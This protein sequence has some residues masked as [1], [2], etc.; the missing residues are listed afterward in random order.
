MQVDYIVIG[1]GSAG[2][3]V[4]ERLSQSG[5]YSVLLLETGGGLHNPWISVPAGFGATY[6]HPKYNYMYYSEK[7]VN[8]NNRQLYVPR[9]KGL[10]GSGSINA[11]IYVRGARR[12]FDDWAKAG[13]PSWAY[14]QVLPYFKQ[15]E[16]HPQGE[17]DYRGAHGPI[18]I[19]PMATNA[20]PICQNF[21]QAT[22]ETGLPQ[23]SD[24]NG[25]HF[26][27]AGIYDTNI[28]AGKRESSYTA[29]LKPSLK[30]RNLSLWTHAKVN[31]LML[32]DCQVK[33]VE[34]VHQGQAKQVSV[35]KEVVLCAGAVA[36]P[37]LLETSGIGQQSRLQ[38]IGIKCL[39]DLPG[40][41]E[42]LQDHLCASFYY[43]ANRRTLND[44][45]GSLSGKIQA[46][47]QYALGRKGP[48]SLSVNQ[49]GGF[50]RGSDS[51]EH[52]NIQMYFNP[53][54]YEIPT[55]P[56]AKL[57][58]L[59]YSGYLIAVN[60]CRPT[61]RG[62]VHI[63]HAMPNN[64]PQIDFNFLSTDHDRQESIQAGNLVRKIAQAPSL[65]TMTLGEEK[66]A[67]QVNNNDEMLQYFQREGNSIYHLSGTC[68]MGPDKQINVV[69]ENLLVHGLAGLRI[70]D[71]SI[72]PN[73]TSGNTNAPTMMVALKA[74]DLIL[75]DN[76]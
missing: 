7:Q 19:T 56:N 52:A 46:G 18:G 37:Q 51:E 43:R 16:Q 26:E 45:F 6:Y 25:Q 10:G 17:T 41:G 48:L 74:A 67:S 42:N 34:V 59:P 57:T 8:M 2:C 72:F 32:Q 75:A 11:M 30:R 53:L 31:R 38:K 40:V 49:A 9:G 4:A 54:S 5:R 3:I 55:N 14:N 68:A 22:Q 36:N 62:S 44:D 47:L 71:A 65:Q 39:L 76:D 61:S 24:F 15:L 21:L 58:P 28:R 20:H 64:A 60:A 12:D 1:A 69:D 35:A 23:N 29:Y 27:G 13:N 33:G 73:I 50:F 63:N 70:A 66:P